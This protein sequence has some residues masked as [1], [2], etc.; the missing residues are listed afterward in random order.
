MWG[1]RN[2][3]T[4]LVGLQV[5]ATTLENNMR[6]LKNLN[7]DLRYDPAI[8]LAGMYPKN[9]TQ[10]TPEAPAHPCLWQHYSQ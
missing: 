10:V 9:A 1:K 6:L 3:C 4:L 2:P 7:I 8:T 5:S